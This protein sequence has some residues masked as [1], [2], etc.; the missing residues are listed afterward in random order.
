MGTFVLS[1]IIYVC[2]YNIYIYIYIYIYIQLIGYL[3]LHSEV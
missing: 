2:V 3:S 1:K